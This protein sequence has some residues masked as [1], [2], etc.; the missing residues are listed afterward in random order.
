MLNY[1]FRN[2]N[3]GRTIVL[4]HGY[5]GNS[6]CFKKQLPIL[7]ELFDILLIDMHGHGMS[8]HLHLVPSEEFTLER[9]VTDI[10]C[11]LNK[12]S[13]TQAHFMGL[14]LGSMVANAYAFHYPEKVLS[15]V[16]VGAIIKLKP[17]DR[18]LMRLVYTFRY[19]LPHMLVFCVA[20]LVIMP[21]RKHQKAREIFI[22][23]AKKM[24]SKDFFA[25]TKI[26]IDF[27]TIYSTEKLD[28]NIPTLYISGA[29]DRVF[30]K[31]VK[32]HCD[33]CKYSELYL[34]ENAGHI[35]NYDDSEGFNYV[36]EEFYQYLFKKRLNA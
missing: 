33:H 28:L 9:I 18:I 19:F 1:D 12:L 22:N 35:C 29:Y 24:N 20:G 36:M 4:L 11:L 15:I 27:E 6:N 26:M 10:D 5:G 25:W 21:R 2:N 34:L 14:S 16:H 7:N 13:I 23:E 3:K 8:K 32:K 30:I 17:F 31:E